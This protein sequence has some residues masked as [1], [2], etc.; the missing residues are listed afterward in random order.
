MTVDSVTDTTVS[1]TWQEVEY[2]EGIENY[3]VYRDG[4][5]VALVGTTSFTDEGLDPDTEYTYQ[6]KAIGSN[7]L[8]SDLSV[9]VSAMTEP[10]EV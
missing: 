2:A 7:G 5:S 9:A 4:D 1:L 10:E 3:E 8:E 6:V